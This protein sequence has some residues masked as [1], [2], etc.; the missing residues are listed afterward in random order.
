MRG[1][2]KSWIYFVPIIVCTNL[3][4]CIL[5]KSFET[6]NASLPDATSSSLESKRKPKSSSQLNQHTSLQAKPWA[7]IPA[8][9][10]RASLTRLQPH[11]PRRTQPSVTPAAV[12]HDPS[13]RHATTRPHYQARPQTRRPTTCSILARA[14]RTR[15]HRVTRTTTTTQATTADILA[16]ARVVTRE[17][18]VVT[19]A[20]VMAAVAAAAAAMV[21][22]VV[23]AK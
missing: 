13:H 22:V 3:G 20:V 10:T 11:A 9:H 4:T 16:G 1:Y 6:V 7:A 17:V 19:R 5:N 14:T 21:V 18:V 23:A 15:L 8:N 2:E 12:Q